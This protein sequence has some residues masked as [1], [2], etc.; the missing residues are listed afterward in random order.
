[1]TK[2]GRQI[3]KWIYISNLCILILF[4]GLRY[5]TGNDYD[6]YMKIFSNPLA[7]GGSPLYYSF[8]YLITKILDIRYIFLI[9]SLISFT[10]F[11]K[12]ANFYGREYRTI[13]L[14]LYFFIYSLQRDM[15]H[16][17]VAIAYGICIY[18]IKYIENKRIFILLIVLASQIHISSLL[19]LL[20]IFIDKIKVRHLNYLIVLALIL[21]QIKYLRG[22]IEYSYEWFGS[23]GYQLKRYLDNGTFTTDMGLSKRMIKDLLFFLG[24]NLFCLE[25]FKGKKENVALKLYGFGIFFSLAVSEIA[26]LVYRGSTIFLAIEIFICTILIKESEKITTKITILLIYLAYGS[27]TYFAYLSHFSDKF[28]PYKTLLF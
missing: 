3:E 25:K 4:T 18:A 28:I 26:I 15:G 19:F 13:S 10:I 1:M 11:H 5:K 20:V 14:G 12:I 21:M 7:K 8:I 27:H 2:Q 24:I 9:N 16:L 22:V 23:A 17:R 6:S